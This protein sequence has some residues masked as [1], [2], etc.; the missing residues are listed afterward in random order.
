MSRMAAEIHEYID[1]ATG[2][3]WVDGDGTCCIEGTFEG[4]RVTIAQVGGTRFGGPGWEQKNARYRAERD[5]NHQFIINAREDLPRVLED[6]EELRRAW[7]SLIAC[8]YGSLPIRSPRDWMSP[9][10]QAIFDHTAY[11]EKADGFRADLLPAS[12]DDSPYDHGLEDS[13][14]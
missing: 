5:A 1:A 3:P 2:E 14:E 10:E 11:L 13:N 6:I 12:D 8:R 9:D 7:L 4:E